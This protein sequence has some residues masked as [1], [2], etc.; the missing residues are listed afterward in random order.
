MKAINPVARGVALVRLSGWFFAM[1]VACPVGAYAADALSKPTAS[2][3][4]NPKEVTLSAVEQ[5]PYVGMDLPNNG[6]AGQVATE[7]FA[8]VGYSV[9]ITFFPVTRAAQLAK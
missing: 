1:L 5:P 7:A 4:A 3:A 8:R 9:K 2:P 6:Y